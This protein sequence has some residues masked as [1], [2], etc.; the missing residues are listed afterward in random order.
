MLSN[1]SALQRFLLISATLGI[2]YDL[3]VRFPILLSRVNCKIT[4]GET[5]G[6]EVHEEFAGAV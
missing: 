3:I 4:A 1:G 5:G 6:D 2:H